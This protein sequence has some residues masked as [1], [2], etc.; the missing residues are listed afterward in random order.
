MPLIGKLIEKAH[1]EPLHVKNNAWQYFLR[2]FLKEATAKS[3]LS[4]ACKKFNDVP[5]DSPFS[6]VVT[7]L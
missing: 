1:M 6:R 5:K 4:G 2:V 7:T 3:N